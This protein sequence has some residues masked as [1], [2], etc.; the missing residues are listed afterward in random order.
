MSGTLNRLHLARYSIYNVFTGHSFNLSNILSKLLNVMHIN[1]YRFRNAQNEIN[2]K[3]Q[4][5]S[6]LNVIHA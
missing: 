5:Q 1:L 2:I 6:P 3:L 4:N